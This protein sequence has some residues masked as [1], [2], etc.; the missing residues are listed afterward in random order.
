[1]ARHQSSKRR[2]EIKRQKKLAYTLEHQR[3]LAEA[4]QKRYLLTLNEEMNQVQ[5]KNLE[6]SKSPRISSLWRRIEEL[7][8]PLA[9]AEI[10]YYRFQAFE[11][12][13]MYLTDDSDKLYEYHERGLFKMY[14]QD[15]LNIAREQNTIEILR[16]KPRLAA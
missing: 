13:G 8:P 5:L 12:L 1:M 3:Q 6:Y 4:E 11:H 7:R 2:N 14:V 15:Q 16:F 10:R 9:A